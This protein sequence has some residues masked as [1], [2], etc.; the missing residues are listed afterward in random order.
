MRKALAL[1]LLATAPACVTVDA[2]QR[3]VWWRSSGGTD[4]T[5]VAEG[6][7]YVPPLA[8]LT[9]YDI[10][11]QQRN[12]QLI[13]I[14]SNG[15]SLGLDTTIR[16]R[17][18]PEGVA[19]L[20]QETG[21]NY[22][23]V[24]LGP[25]LRSQARRVVGRYTPEEIYSTKRELIEREMREAVDKAIAGKHIVLEAILVRN[26]A[27]PE[28]IQRAI[29]DKLSE[30]Q[31]ALKMKFVLERAQQEAERK[32][33][34]A[35]GVAAFQEIVSAKISE[36][37]LRWKQLEAIEHLAQSPNAKVVMLNGGKET[38]LVIEAPR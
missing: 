27:L 32:R 36:A 23:D 17:L 6:W 9:T 22:Y 15:L 13:V 8:S 37:L 33:I 29:I 12:E 18:D 38:P 5:P 14:S 26:V 30:E 31:S 7:Y 2:G 10:R 16:F 24:I 28:L 11:S 19:M 34:E 20:H 4:L 21:P 1:V 35:Q 3:G 25:V